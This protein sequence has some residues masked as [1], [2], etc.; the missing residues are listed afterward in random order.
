MTDNSFNSSDSQSEDSVKNGKET[1]SQSNKKNDDKNEPKIKNKKLIDSISYVLS[2]ILNENKKLKNY[3][4]II[5]NQSNMVFSAKSIPSISI[6]DYLTR[7]QIYSEIEKSTLILALIQIDHICKKS[8]LI[9][10][11]Y[12]IHRLLFGAVLISIKYNE[13]LYYDNIFYSEIGG[14][15][16]RELKMIE[17]TFLELNQFNVFVNHEEYEQYRIYLEEFNK[18]PDEEK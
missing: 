18:I 10:T 13:D 9:L 11:Y 17:L 6:N 12:N 1:K 8:K 7:I 2:T 14:V 16:L 15:K 5:K 4:E 3:K